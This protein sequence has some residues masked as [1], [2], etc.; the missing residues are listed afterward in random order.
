MASSGRVGD[1]VLGPLPPF[2]G[3]SDDGRYPVGVNPFRS[4]L[5]RT[6][7]L[8]VVGFAAAWVI[9]Y[10]FAP[11]WP[12]FCDE[13][14][15]GAPC[16]PVQTQTMM[17]YIVI[18]L[19]VLTMIFGPIAGSLID[20]ALNGANWETPRGTEN[21]ITNVPLLIGAIYLASGVLIVATA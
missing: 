17:G 4:R 8:T 19:G 6:V 9:A 16:D 15:V 1:S 20:L 10:V 2:R 13:T 7:I 18:A 12:G 5:L 11:L 21:V 3:P 14:I